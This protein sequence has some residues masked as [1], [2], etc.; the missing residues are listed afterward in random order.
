MDECN[1]MVVINQD[2]GFVLT[3]LLCVVCHHRL[4]NFLQV[5]SPI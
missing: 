4:K 1:M 5:L 3:L 2:S